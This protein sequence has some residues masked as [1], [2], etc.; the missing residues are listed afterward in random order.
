MR[1]DGIDT[2]DR[3]AVI[4]ECAKRFKKS[5]GWWRNLAQCYGA[6]TKDNVIRT[7]VE[8][9]EQGMYS[10]IPQKYKFLIDAPFY[11]TDK[12]CTVMKKK[13]AHDFQK[14]HGMNPIT[15]QMASESRM[16]ERQWVQHGCNA[17][18][19]IHPISNPMAFWTE[20]DVLR[21]LK[22]NNIKIAS[23]Y[24]DIVYVDADGNQYDELIC[25]D[26]AKLTTTKLKRTGCMFCGFGCHLGEKP[27][28]FQVMKEIHPK[29]YN[30]LMKPTDD[31]GLGYKEI[32]DWMNEHGNLNIMY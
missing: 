17:F 15:A 25:T 1:A 9:E 19:A 3:D 27:P 13:P 2:T 7:D 5:A 31:G 4:E 8:K 12:C 21:Y 18:D 29:I 30:Y 20:Q 16:R 24:G 10:E 26:N 11:L 22:E 14:Q 6:V 23:V 32:I 28:R